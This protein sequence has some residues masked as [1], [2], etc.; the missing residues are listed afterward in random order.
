MWDAAEG[1]TGAKL[2]GVD[3]RPDFAAL[4]Y[5]VITMEKP[6]VHQGSR[7]ALLGKAPAPDLVAKY[8]LERRAR[9]NMPPIFLVA[10]MADQSVPVENSLHFYQALRDAGVPAE[11]HVYAR[12]SHGNSLDPQYG[13]TASWPQRL[14]E[15][16]RSNG[17]LSAG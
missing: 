16:M 2:D 17:W 14:A 4:I 6:S 13:P 3:A 9:R 7:D 1:N 10:T 5:P 8:S 15:W 11:M 12:G